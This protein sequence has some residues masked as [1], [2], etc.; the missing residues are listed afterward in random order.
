MTS[1]GHVFLEKYGWYGEESL[2]NTLCPGVSRLNG[3]P[4]YNADIV[5]TNEGQLNL[6]SD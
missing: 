5:G 6:I 2:P 1:S 4:K 3:Q